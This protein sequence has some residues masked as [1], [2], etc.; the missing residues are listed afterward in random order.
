MKFYH[1]RNSLSFILDILIW[2][3]GFCTYIDGSGES[4]KKNDWTLK[5]KDA[6]GRG[7]L[8]SVFEVV[9]L[10]NSPQALM[11][12]YVTTYRRKYPKEIMTFFFVQVFDRF[13]AF[14]FSF[15]FPYTT[16]LSRLFRSFYTLF[17]ASL[18]H[19]KNSPALSLIHNFCHFFLFG[20]SFFTRYIFF[21]L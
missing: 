14:S 19:R 2:F 6:A 17:F 16:L 18:L 8:L 11:I 13:L 4:E 3:Y 21:S 5:A 1:L 20:F 7:L 10:F 12:H 15:L 9:N